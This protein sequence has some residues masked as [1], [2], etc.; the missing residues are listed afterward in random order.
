MVNLSNQKKKS[1]SELII[2]SYKNKFFVSIPENI[3][4]NPVNFK[5]IVKVIKIII[6]DK[7]YGVYNLG[8]KGKI[9][10]FQF[11]KYLLKNKRFND[12]FIKPYISKYQIHKRPLNTVMH[13]GKLEK[14]IN[15]KLPTIKNSIINSN[16]Y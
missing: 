4:F 12:K 14:K 7:T 2:E 15:F 11:A 1:F 16:R 6:K 13:T 5:T 10:K 3:Y 9:S 8:S